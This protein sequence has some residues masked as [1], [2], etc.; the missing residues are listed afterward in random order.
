MKLLTTRISDEMLKEV[1]KIH[2]KKLGE[3]YLNYAY[4]KR[5]RDKDEGLMVACDD[6]DDVLGYL[7]YEVTSDTKFFESKHLDIESKGIPALC[8]LTMAVDNERKGIGTFLTSSCIDMFKDKVDV[9]YSPVW[10]SVNGI[11][12]DRLL[13]R[14]GFVP[15]MEIEDY[16]YEDSLGVDDYCPVCGSPC[17]CSLLIYELLVSK[18]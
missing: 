4:F 13:R 9:L 18:I 6:N 11:N 12:A 1:Y 15:S 17:R 7:V 5:L 8:L 10:K 14:M 16:W 3:G 2:Q